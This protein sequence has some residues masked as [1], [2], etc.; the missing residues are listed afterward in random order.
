LGNKI[1]F[2]DN[3]DSHKYLKELNKANVDLIIN[4]I[5]IPYQKFLK[6]QK[7]GLYNITLNL[8]IALTDCSNM[9]YNSKYLT[10]IDFSSFYTKQITNMEGMFSGCKNLKK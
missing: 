7:E 3:T 5:K 4:N 1:Y 8:K 6:F 9:F 2:L 10:Q